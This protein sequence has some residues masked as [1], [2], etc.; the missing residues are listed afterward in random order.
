MATDALDT[1]SIV[2]PSWDERRWSA[3]AA[4]D[5]PSIPSWVPAAGNSVVLASGGVIT[6]T[7]RSTHITEDVFYSS[8][9][10]NA[11]S[12]TVLHPTWRELGGV[13]FIGG[14]HANT[15]YNAIHIATF[16]A[17]SIYYERL[18]DPTNWAAGDTGNISGEWNSYAEVTGSSPL[19]IAGGHSYGSP[20]CIDGKIERV[21]RSA[22]MY[23]GGGDTESQSY[24]SLDLTNP[25]TASSARGWVRETNDLGAYS[26]TAVPLLSAYAA[27]QNRIYLMFRSNTNLRWFDRAAKTWVTGSG[28][29]W[30]YPSA[31]TD[32]SDCVTGT[33]FAVPERHLIVA[34]FR[35][36]GNLKLQY[37]Q[38]TQGQPSA[39]TPTLGATLALPVE[40]GKAVCWCNDS[41]K[42][43]VFGVT[44]NNDKCYEVTI[45]E[46]LTDTWAIDSWVMGGAG[47]VDPVSVMTRAGWGCHYH[48]GIRAVVMAHTLR[49]GTGGEPDTIDRFTVIRP[50]NT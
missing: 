22:M 9:M 6:N 7:W 46:T 47:S 29:G 42:I 13:V 14:G 32:A 40:G 38:T 44:S 25:A 37:I 5:K 3:Y 1:R 12:G 41:G 21:I 18:V 33:L 15:N 49:H 30:D 31:D 28:T 23:A 10:R 4:G 34:A 50:R 48:S 26:G 43:L 39:V 11:Y 8:K 2:L 19:Q 27:D 20:Q 17:D 45:P 35:Q 16:A 36:G 24:H